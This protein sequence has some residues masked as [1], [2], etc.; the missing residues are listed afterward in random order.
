MSNTKVL[1][2]GKWPVSER[3]LAWA[4]ILLGCLLGGAAYPLFLTPNRIAP[5]GL[6][7]VATILNSFWGVP[8]GMASLAM[9][10]PLFLAGWRTMGLRF[11]FRSLGATV[12]FSLAIDLIAVGPMTD[13]ALLAAICGGAMSGVGFGLI[14]R[15]GATTGGTD[16]L[17]KMV[18]HRF[19]TITMGM[20]LF[21]IDFC[22]VVAAGLSLGSS[23]ALYALI[24]IFLQSKVIDVVIVGLTANKACFI[25]AD[26]WEQIT[27]RLLH[28]MDRGVTLLD[29]RGAWSGKGRPVVLC[30]I[31]R[32]ELPQ[33]KQIVQEEDEAAFM[34]V[35]E[36]FEALGEGFAR[37]GRED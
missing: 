20:F 21:A 25:M 6:T 26:G 14:L 13:D 19:P 33:I 36:A 4:Q 15:G 27:H 2:R 1:P 29:A 7:G 8:V 34:F 12:L 18:H 5:G 17:A 37:F 30:V 28:E 22:V 3:V 24:T 35:T 23:E 11:A 31:S 9:N 10:I 16:M 32:Q